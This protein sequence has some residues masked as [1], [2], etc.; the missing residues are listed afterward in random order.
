MTRPHYQ[1]IADLRTIS[2]S[3]AAITLA[4]N[5]RM[6]KAALMAFGARDLPREIAAAMRDGRGQ[7]ALDSLAHD[8]QRECG[9]G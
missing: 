2:P 5:R 9:N 3:A 1:E 8:L 4:T 7:N 6:L